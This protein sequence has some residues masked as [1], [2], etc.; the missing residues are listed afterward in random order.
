MFIT[1]GRHKRYNFHAVSQQQIFFCY[2]TCSYSTNGFSCA[3]TSS[4]TAGLDTVLFLVGV[5]C[6][7]RPWEHV[8]CASTVILWS[9]IFIFH[10]QPNWR[11][12][13]NTELCPGLY[14]NSVFLISRSCESALSWASAGHL[15]LDIIFCQFHSRRTAINYGS[16][17]A[18]MRFAI[19]EYVS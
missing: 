8:H 19:T 1:N 16:Y 10:H 9:L 12:Q 7:A 11:P 17:R 13:C 15:R 6:M 5:I 2:G 3:A 4:T 14:L 18:T